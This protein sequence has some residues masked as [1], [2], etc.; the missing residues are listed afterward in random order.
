MFF[1]SLVYCLVCI[2]LVLFS[3]R[4]FKKTN[5]IY[6]LAILS[7]QIIAT[8][9]EVARA[10]LSVQNLNI[11]V[12]FFIFVFGI[13]IPSVVF[14]SDYFG[15]NL[16]EFVDIKMGD[17]FMKKKK[18]LKAIEKY[19]KALL[20]NS[21]SATTFSK[22]GHAYNGIGDKRTAFDRFARAVELDRNDYKSYYEIGIIFN[23]MN[24]KK[25]AEVVL[26][27]ALRI[28]PDFT[29]AS[30]LLANV[31][32]SQNKFDDAIRI[33]KEAI[34]YESE[35]YELFYNLGLIHTELRD[36]ND[37]LECYKSVIKLNPEHGESYFSIGQIYLLK[38]EFDEALKSFESVLYDKDL[39]ARA[40]YQMARVYILKEDEISA[41][42]YIQKAIDLDPTYR[43]KAEKEP[44]F[45]SIKEYLAGMQMVSK[46]Q[47]KL[48]QEI[49]DKV[50]EKYEKEMNNIHF[51]YMDKFSN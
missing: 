39:S 27:N 19:Q 44:L 45:D 36:F 34:K 4:A 22:L 5:K 30:M 50:K 18:Y 41:A 49:D 13:V 37:A 43:Y 23:E 24:K 15:L 46:A 17:L 10:I 1:E 51:D 16:T 48:E 14:M 21:T 8:V 7:M 6:I 35:N 29:D 42:S 31:L 9:V 38:G 33:Y 3:L 2:F 32:C 26:D 11:G 47:M 12:E 40:Y 20:Q 25:D 28:K